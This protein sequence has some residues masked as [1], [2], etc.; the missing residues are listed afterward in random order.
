MTLSAAG[1]TYKF[2]DESAGCPGCVSW[3]FGYGPSTAIDSHCLSFCRCSAQYSLASFLLSPK[4]STQNPCHCKLLT[5]VPFAS[6]PHPRT[7]Q[8]SVS[9]FPCVG[10][11]FFSAENRT[12]NERSPQVARTPP[13]RWRGTRRRPRPLVQAWQANA[14]LSPSAACSVSR[15]VAA[16]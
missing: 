14:G 9:V 16:E 10:A 1:R 11:D 3:P 5:A 15:S 6:T 8:L 13:S 7:P 4:F 2:F 12:E